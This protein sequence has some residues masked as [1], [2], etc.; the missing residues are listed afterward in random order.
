[1]SVFDRHRI[2]DHDNEGRNRRCLSVDEMTARGFTR[3]ARGFWRER[4]RSQFGIMADALMTARPAL[5][6]DRA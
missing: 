6:G 4:V 3:N 5:V 2:G 1:M